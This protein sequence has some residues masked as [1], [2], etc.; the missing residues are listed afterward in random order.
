M[1]Q[2]AVKLIT[3]NGR[4]HPS[5]SGQKGPN[6]LPET[7]KLIRIGRASKDFEG[8]ILDLEYMAQV[9]A[10]TV[11][12]LISGDPTPITGKEDHFFISKDAANVG[13]FTVYHLHDMIRVFVAKYYAA[14][15]N[16]G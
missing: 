3:S 5:G 1:A 13:M 12:D 14:L 8:D 16:E 7:A 15:E 6:L 4:D 10:A 11:E 9:V 2:A